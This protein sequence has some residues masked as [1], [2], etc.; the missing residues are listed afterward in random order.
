MIGDEIIAVNAQQ[1]AVLV[2]DV[3]NSAQGEQDRQAPCFGLSL[4]HLT[5]SMLLHSRSG[6]AC[7]VTVCN[8]FF[9]LHCRPSITCR[10]VCIDS[11]ILLMPYQASLQHA[12]CLKKYCVLWVVLE[13]AT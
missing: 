13:Q 1:Y 12:R 10:A 11:C 2:M 7:E 6:M 5:V 8:D 9:M 3:P 4:T